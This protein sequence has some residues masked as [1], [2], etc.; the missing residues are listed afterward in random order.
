ML[1]RFNKTAVLSSDDILIQM[2]TSLRILPN[3]K[4]TL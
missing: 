3:F 1:F 2:A 4:F